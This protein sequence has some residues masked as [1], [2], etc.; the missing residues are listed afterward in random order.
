MIVTLSPLKPALPVSESI[1]CSSVSWFILSPGL[2]WATL[3]LT[4]DFPYPH[5]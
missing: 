4:R 1:H 2:S 5:P 3:I